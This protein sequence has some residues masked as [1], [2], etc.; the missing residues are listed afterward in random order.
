MTHC[1]SYFS[2]QFLTRCLSGLCLKCLLTGFGRFYK[3]LPSHLSWLAPRFKARQKGHT[4]LSLFSCWQMECVSFPPVNQFAI[5]GGTHGN[6][7][8]GVYMVREMQ[9]QKI[10]KV[11]SVSIITAL[12]N[13]RAVD[14][15]KRYTETD[16]NRCFTDALLRYVH[17]SVRLKSNWKLVHKSMPVWE[18]CTISFGFQCPHNRFNTLWVEASPRAERSAWAQRKW[19]GRGSALR[20][21]QHHCQHGPVPHLL[22]LRLDHPAHLQIHTGTSLTEARQ[23][24]MGIQF[25]F[26]KCSFLTCNTREWSAGS[27]GDIMQIFKYVQLNTEFYLHATFRISK[28]LMRKCPKN[29]SMQNVMTSVSETSITVLFNMKWTAWAIVDFWGWYYYRYVRVWTNIAV[30]LIKIL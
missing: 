28:L 16:L 4:T 1:P 29:A 21:P 5:C 22:F 9:K 11:G 10:E 24:F 15:C 20:S 18:N 30:F 7:M 12:S 2:P 8:S 19:R 25:R 23:I 13:P 27:A 6:E 14:A 17:T 3:S 26:T